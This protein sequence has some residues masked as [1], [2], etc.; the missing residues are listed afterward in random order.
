MRKVLYVLLGLALLGGA[1]GAFGMRYLDW[2]PGAMLQSERG[3]G[4]PRAFGRERGGGE[5]RRW[6][7]DRGHGQSR[8]GGW[9]TFATILDVLNVIV[10]VVGIVLTVSGLRMQRNAMTM[11]MRG[12][13]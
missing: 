8:G 3:A 2:Q 9:L 12:R 13:D 1:A 5:A 6:E 10:G 4:G 11:T 7:G